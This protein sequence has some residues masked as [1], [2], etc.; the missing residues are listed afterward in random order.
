MVIAGTSGDQEGCPLV[1]VTAS[2]SSEPSY[3]HRESLLLRW[4]YYCVANLYFRKGES[5]VRS[6]GS[7]KLCFTVDLLVILLGGFI[8]SDFVLK[9]EKRYLTNV[10]Y[11]V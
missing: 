11:V 7:D 6:D 4:G 9:L 10:R 3:R 5:K 8:Y 1:S 2:I